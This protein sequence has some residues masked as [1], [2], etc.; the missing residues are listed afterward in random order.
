PSV[1]L[2]LMIQSL[3]T[4]QVLFKNVLW[5][6]NEKPPL[7]KME[8]L[9]KLQEHI[10]FDLEIFQILERLKRGEKIKS[11]NILQTFERYLEALESL[12]EK[13]NSI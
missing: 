10:P 3:S 11:L 6:F 2:S 12:I 5:L 13:V 7:K 4:F 1:V 9:K 8:A